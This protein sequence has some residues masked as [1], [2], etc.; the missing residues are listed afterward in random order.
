MSQ[1]TDMLF[2]MLKQNIAGAPN[3]AL[4]LTTLEMLR[5]E[6]DKQAAT[7]VHASSSVITSE[8][9]VDYGK[10]GYTDEHDPRS[11]NAR[12]HSPEGQA[13]EDCWLIVHS[14]PDAEYRCV[15]AKVIGE[16]Q[17]GGRH[18]ATVIQPG[19]E[20]VGLATGY[21]GNPDEF[22]QLILHSPSDD[23]IIDGHGQPPDLG[24]YSVFLVRNGRA[25]SDRVS[26]IML[27]FGHHIC[28]VFEFARR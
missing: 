15:S 26:S 8:R 6:V 4:A 9:P 11:P 22:D 24:P 17:A 23:L 25:I 1:V 5:S 18:I 10:N 12:R 21:N 13:V 2:T 19:S 7:G 14:R 27:P 3:E 28:Y 20:Q 16:S